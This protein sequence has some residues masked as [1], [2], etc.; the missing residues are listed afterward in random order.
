MSSGPIFVSVLEVRMRSQ[1]IVKSWAPPIRQKRPPDD[2]KEFGKDI[3]QNAV[4]GSDRS[5]TAATEIAFFFNPT[6]FFSSE[7]ISFSNP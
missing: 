4:H 2:R 1:E 3:E 5:E 6:R 7:L